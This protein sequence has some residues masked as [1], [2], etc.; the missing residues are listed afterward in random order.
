MV[1][2]NLATAHQLAERWERAESYLVQ[3]LRNF[4]VVW[5][6]LPSPRLNWFCRVEKYHLALIQA[7]MRERQQPAGRGLGVDNLFPGLRF[8]GP[9]G[10]YEAG[11]LAADQ[12]PRP[13]PRKR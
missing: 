2:G 12:W 7:R 8:V 13:F 3:S 1:L 4:P 5:V 6:G 10:E 11:S 9:S